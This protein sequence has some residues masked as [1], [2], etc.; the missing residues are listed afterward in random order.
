VKG[1]DA[2]RLE[3]LIEKNQKEIAELADRL[4]QLRL[5]NIK[6]YEELRQINFGG[7]AHG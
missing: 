7:K 6:L 3:A 2:E 5:Q 4:E 1:L